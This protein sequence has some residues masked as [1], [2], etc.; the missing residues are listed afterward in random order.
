MV[1]LQR[2]DRRS[3][4]IGVLTVLDPD[5]STIFEGNLRQCCHCSMVWI[6]K[7]GSG[8]NRGFCSKCEDHICG[9]DVCFI[10]YPAEQRDEDMER[11]ARQ[12]MTPGEWDARLRQE[13][14][15]EQAWRYEVK[16]KKLERAWAV[17]RRR[18]AI[19]VTV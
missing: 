1:Y 16:K 13:E 12:L 4:R 7:P 15:R 14:F 17:D 11:A 2:T 8:I 19:G 18:D 5:K 3:E 10:C 9:K 6:Y